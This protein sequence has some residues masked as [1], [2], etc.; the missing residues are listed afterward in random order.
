M[1]RLAFRRL[2]GVGLLIFAG[3]LY[4]TRAERID[5]ETLPT[6]TPDP[7]NGEILFW[8]GGCASCH[9]APGATGEARLVMAGGVELETPFGLFRVPNISPDPQ[10]GIG[11]W[12]TADFVTAMVKGTSPQGAHYYPAFPYASYKS[13]RITDVIDLKAYLD[14]LPASANVVADHDLPFP[15]PWR[16]ALG[17][18]KALYLDHTP[19]P[20][21]PDADAQVRRGHYLVAGAG[22]CAECHTPRDGFGGLDMSRWLAGGPD[23]EG[24]GRVPDITASGI[25]A[26]SAADIAYYLES[27]FTPDF[28]SVGGTMAS[29]QQNW[30]KVPAADREAVAAY[31]KTLPAAAAGR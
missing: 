3:L 25:G 19:P 1:T 23:P 17:F 18:W 16:G 14:T 24:K 15:I 27:G 13:M 9:A 5:A 21:A 10:A 2:V 11:G 30:A 29:V 8:A 31:L 4:L 26:W 20:P 28:D 22:H 7:A 6:H 12:T